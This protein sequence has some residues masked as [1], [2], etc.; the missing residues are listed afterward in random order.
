MN[1]ILAVENK[2]DNSKNKYNKKKNTTA[3]IKKVISVFC[4]ITILFGIAIAGQGVYAIVN[5]FTQNPNT[6]ITVAEQNISIDSNV[7]TGKVIISGTVP[8]GVQK[9][10][11]NWN[12]GEEQTITKNGETELNEEI[13]LPVGNNKLNLTIVDMKNISTPYIKE[14]MADSTLP[15]LALSLSED[16]TKI[17]ITAKDTVALS[18]VTYQWDAN[19][20]QTIYPNEGS[21]AQIEEEIEA[22]AG[23]HTLTVIAVNTN[24]RTIT[25]TQEVDG[26]SKPTV[27]A[28]ID[29]SDRSKIIFS[30]SDESGLN[31]LSFVINGQRYVLPATEGQKE[32][33]YTFEVQQGHYSITVSAENIYGLQESKDFLYDY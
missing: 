12:E 5:N 24:N 20:I 1:Q 26:A 7:N 15:Q 22:I 9:I 27:N 32:L 11:Y 3:D 16:G 33:Q 6:P 21:E 2:K 25:R 18:Y 8:N 29:Q 28:Q 17:K 31:N 4:I 13:D 23:K 14:F 10:T 19:D 30:A